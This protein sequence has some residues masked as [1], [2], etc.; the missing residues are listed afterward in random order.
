[1]KRVVLLIALVSACAACGGDDEILPDA[2][3]TG[4]DAATIS[5]DAAPPTSTVFAVGTDFSSAGIAST[6]T[7]PGLS[8]TSNAVAGVASTDPVVRHIGDKL[9]IVNRFG[10]D[11]VTI[12]DAGS[13]QLDTQISTGS[14]SNP[15]DVAIKGN[16]IY[17][18]ALGAAGVLVLD[19]TKPGEG[20]QKTID[21]TSLDTDDNKPNCNSLTLVGDKLFVTCQ[22]LD[23]TDQFLT[24][25]GPGKVAVIDTTNDMLSTNFALTNKNPLGFLQSTAAGGAYGGDLL[26]AT[27]PNYGDLSEGCVERI[28]TGETPAAGG[29]LVQNSDLG[30]YAGGIAV[31]DDDKIWFAVV[32][33]FD[34]TDFGPLGKVLTYASSTL[35]SASVTPSGQRPFDVA[36]CPTGQVAVSDATA[37]VRVYG[38][39]GTELTTAA[40]DIGLPPV[41]S[42]LVCY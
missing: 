22:I 14:G 9:Y 8:V 32:E 1:M 4:T 19:A 27:V 37:G 18:A 24:P 17:V 21:L 28:S 23:D 2:A 3:Y 42:G 38:S 5:P 35:S 39:D 10:A 6:I 31:Q 26:I 30:G 7:V 33:G 29:C 20:V 25:R 40:L 36:L 34:S 15:Q 16:T 12:V 13:L 11:N 41:S